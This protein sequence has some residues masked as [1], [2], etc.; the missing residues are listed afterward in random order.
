MYF[1]TSNFSTGH[2]STGL[3]SSHSDSESSL[4]S[5]NSE[6]NSMPSLLN[7]NGNAGFD[8]GCVGGKDILFGNPD[9]SSAD[10]SFFASAPQAETTGSVAFNSAET[11]GSIAF[12]GTETAGSVACGSGD[13][14]GCSGGG[15]SSFC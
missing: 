4:L 6:N 8:T 2:S 12:G 14:G 7:P 1:T 11:T 3:L 10:C 5:N 15:F 9:L 13:S